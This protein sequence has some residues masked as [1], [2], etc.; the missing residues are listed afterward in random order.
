VFAL[1]DLNS[2]RSLVD[3]VGTHPHVNSQAYLGFVLF[4][5]GYPDQAFAQSNAAIADARRLAHPPSLAVN[6]AVGARLLSLVGDNALLGEWVDQLVAVTTEHGFRFW[7]A[8][9]TIYLGWLKVKNGDLPGGISLLRSGSAA[10]RAT[11]AEAWMPHYLALLAGACEI[12]GQVEEASTLLDD[13]LQIVERTGERWFAAELNRYKG[14]LLLRQGQSEAAEELYRRALS[15]A[16]EQEAKLWELRAAASL[17]G[18]R[19]D[20]GR[21]TEARDVLAPVYAWFTEGFG[22]PD[23]REAKALLE[24]LDA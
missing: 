24:A 23:L 16:E 18:L 9:G 4:C 19:R 6:L 20:Q 11:G 12:A 1:Y 3:Q 5:L 13:A 14:Q 8:Q 10:Y 7:R 17:A 21:H 2:H 15:I 22:T